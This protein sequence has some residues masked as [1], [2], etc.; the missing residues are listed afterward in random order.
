[1]SRDWIFEMTNIFLI[2]HPR[3]MLTSLMKQL[4]RPTLEETGLPQ[5]LELFETLV[6][7]G[8]KPIV[9]DSKTVLQQ[10]KELLTLLCN[11]LNI[12]FYEEMLSWPAGHRE[13][14][15]VWAPHWYASVEASTGFSP[16]KEKE[17]LV[18]TELESL[19]LEC[20]C[21]YETLEEHIL[22]VRSDD[23]TNL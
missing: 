19:C 6:S 11:K 20:E 2:R 1:M 17:E 13:S 15:G 8:L 3:E 12:P 16:W 23:V 10:P 21:I 9:I 14:D 5:Q 4:P 22:T 7:H 18:P